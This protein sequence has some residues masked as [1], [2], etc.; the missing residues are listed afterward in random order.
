LIYCAREFLADRAS[1]SPLTASTAVVM[2]R[3]WT[4]SESAVR[5]SFTLRRVIC[6]RFPAGTRAAGVAPL[7]CTVRC[8]A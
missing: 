1:Y 3:A 7:A 2:L 8:T 4:T 5:H 6:Q